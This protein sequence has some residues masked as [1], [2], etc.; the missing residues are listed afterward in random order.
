MRHILLIDTLDKLVIKKDSSL[1]LALTLKEQGHEVYLLFEEKLYFENTDIFPL[2]VESF[3]GKYSKN[4]FYIEEFETVNKHQLTI[5]SGDCIHMRLDPPFDTRYLRVLWILKCFESKGIRILNS[6]SGLLLHNEKLI[7]YNSEF[8]IPTFVGESVEDFK[9][10]VKELQ[11]SG[12]EGLILKPIDLYQG[13]GV[14]KILFSE[15]AMKGED[16]V[17]QTKVRKLQGPLVAQP[18]IKDVEKG[19]VRALFYKGQ[20]LGSILKIP[21]EGEFLANIAR[22]ASYEKT[23]LNDKQIVGCQYFC[24]LLGRD[25]VDWIAFDIIGD[26]FSEVNITCP[27]LLV[28]VSNALGKNLSIEIINNF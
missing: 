13:I 16:N 5:S 1:L 18:Y 19:E 7:A 12:Y 17:F 11:N 4:T 25:G 14:E 15:L 23:T 22:G 10:F 20:E 28:E 21:K 3:Q 27:G 6:S 2:E 9:I 26:K 24:D 8:S